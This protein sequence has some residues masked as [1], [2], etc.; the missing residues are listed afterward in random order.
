MRVLL[1]EHTEKKE[2]LDV[3]VRMPYIRG[4][5]LR[6]NIE[7]LYIRHN[8]IRIFEKTVRDFIPDLMVTNKDKYSRLSPDKT[9][10][11][12]YFQ[13]FYQKRF[14]KKAD[15]FR[16]IPVFD[17][18]IREEENESGYIPH[19][20]LSNSCNYSRSIRDNVLYKNLITAEKIKMRGCTF[21]TDSDSDVRWE[22]R[23]NTHLRNIF[24]STLNYLQK[25]ENREVRI[26]GEKYIQRPGKI[27]SLLMHLGI[28]DLR[29]IMTLRPEI[30]IDNRKDFAE[31]LT[32]ASET[33][34]QM[35]LC[36]VGI[37]S[38]YDKDLLLF[39]R[40]LDSKGVLEAI[41]VIYELKDVFRE[42]LI[43]NRYELFNFILFHPFTTTES[44][45][46]NLRMMKAVGINKISKRTFLNRLI[47][48][49]NS[50]IYYLI[51]EEGLSAEKACWK[52]RERNIEEFHN[53]LFMADTHSFK[54]DDI[55][56][57]LSE[58]R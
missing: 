39:N 38:F 21:C 6:N 17:A 43:L 46:Y 49:R 42:S 48:E 15:I 19:L 9:I 35:I 56:Q 10:L 16:M 36:S 58:Y 41:S 8:D 44:I 37:E 11:S 34:N 20:V 27:F 14:G 2:N 18:D 23:D 26:I 57:V 32:V 45:E 1:A 50:A 31:A 53:R 5:L 3:D 7:S 28:K 55:L 51:K 25:R 4:F 52:F 54:T 22:I 24:V 30:L 13:T 29:V 12:R 47:A 40:Y 33:G